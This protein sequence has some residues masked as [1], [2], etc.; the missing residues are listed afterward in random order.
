MKIIW[1]IF[2]NSMNI[3]CTVFMYLRTILVQCG[4]HTDSALV[5]V[6]NYF[7]VISNCHKH[8][9]HFLNSFSSFSRPE[10][11]FSTIP[12]H[13]FYLSNITIWTQCTPN[14]MYG[15]GTVRTQCSLSNSLIAFPI[16]RIDAHSIH[17]KAVVYYSNLNVKVEYFNW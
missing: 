14:W 4:W 10:Y 13:T 9:Q 2:I 16:G 11:K 3:L 8:L 5:R 7:G 12:S 1:S 17:V 6:Q 15:T